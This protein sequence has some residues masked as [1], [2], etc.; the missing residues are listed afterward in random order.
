MTPFIGQI[1]PFG[2]NFAP[3][4]WLL[5]NGGTLPIAQNTALFSLLGTTFGG[6]GRTT[7]GIPDLRGRS[8][9][10]VGTGPGMFPIRW[11]EVLG[12]QTTTLIT[13]NLPA[14]SHTG[15]VH[16]TSQDALVDEPSD[17]VTFGTG[18]TI[19]STGANDKTM[20]AGTVTTNNTGNNQSFNN[21]APGL[22]VY[23]SISNTGVYPSRT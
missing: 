12:S 1:Q 17:T 14:H 15:V 7:F 16:A 13:A 10:H 6:D 5:C 21:Y 19:Y 22:G 11:G 2:F 8:I 3:R 4:G 20:R 23:V 9:V 18:Q